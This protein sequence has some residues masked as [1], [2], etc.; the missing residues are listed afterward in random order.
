MEKHACEQI[1]VNTPGSYV[2]QCYEGY[3]L[4]ANGKNCIGEYKFSN[5]H[6]SLDTNQREIQCILLSSL[7][8]DNDGKLSSPI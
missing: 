8:V 3:E 5:S 1:C 2:C 7:A 4:D 6:L